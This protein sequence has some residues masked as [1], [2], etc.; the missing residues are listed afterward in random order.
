MRIQKILSMLLAVIMLFSALSLL[1]SCNAGSVV[2]DGGDREGDSW[3]G[4]NFE[5]QTV[6]MSI[7][8]N[9]CSECTFPAADIYTKGPDTAGSNEVA[10]EVLSRNADAERLLGI[11][12][13]YV[14]TDWHFSEVQGDIRSIVQTA[15]KNSPDV[16]N[17]DMYGLCRAMV[18]GLLWNVKNP[19][20]EVKS[21]FDF[22]ADGWYHEFM[23]GCTFDQN[24]YYTFAGDYFIDMIRMAWVIYVNHDIFSANIGKMP[25]WCGSLNEFYEYVDAGFWDMDVL[26]DIIGRVH[27]DGGKLGYTECEDP[28]VGI[29]YNHGSDWIVSSSAQI[30]LYY[31]DKED[32]YK[33]KVMDSVDTFQK[34][35]DKY[36][37]MMETKGALYDGLALS[38]T[39]HFLHG[40]AL[41]AFSRLGEM[42]STQLRDFPAAKGLVPVPKWD[43]NQQEDYHTVVSDQIEVG[44]ILKTA[45]A[46]SAA[47]ALMQY[48]NENSK[49]VVHAYYEKGLKYKYNDDK[50]ARAMMDIVRETTDA[51][52]GMQIGVLCQSLYTGTGTLSGMKFLKDHK[53]W[54]SVYNSEKD[55]Y[56]DCLNKMIEKFEKLD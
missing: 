26:I 50:N 55:A 2:T 47:S 20:E 38:S 37:E 1:A 39:E 21:Y 3:D 28:V 25:H 8:T 24:K 7:S 14:E 23:K 27:V 12:I 29:A 34:L 49:D 6:K 40:N 19:G 56:V 48:L 35:A 44:A 5:G 52:F 53:A 42:E 45:R 33:P 36:A 18:D 51:P 22:E 54:S 41:F 13:E 9:Q 46:F 43:D 10:K 30:T 32:G 16:Y 17:N 31:Q 4:V 15:S 11:N